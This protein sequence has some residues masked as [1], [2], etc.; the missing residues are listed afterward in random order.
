MTGALRQQSN[1]LKLYA[2]KPSENSATC[3]DWSTS[4]A[5]STELQNV[6]QN[7]TW[8]VNSDALASS[9][10]A[11]LSLFPANTGNLRWIVGQIQEQAYVVHGPVFLKVRFEEPSSFH[12]HL[13]YNIK[14]SVPDQVLASFRSK[15]L[16]TNP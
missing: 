2:L 6:N 10:F 12:V 8:Q 15:H 5:N 14:A 16:I 9:L 4:I 3:T 11:L 7:D 1:S 13:N